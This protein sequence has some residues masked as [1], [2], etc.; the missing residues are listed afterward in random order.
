MRVLVTGSSG[1][2]G[3]TLVPLLEAEGHAV[4]GLDLVPAPTTHV[5]GSITDRPLV[6]P[7]TD[8]VEPRQQMVCVLVFSCLLIITVQ[9]QGLGVSR[10]HLV[11]DAFP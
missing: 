11:L 6:F 5:R 2:L 8:I 9:E 1:W 4:T 7:A 10:V 3:Q